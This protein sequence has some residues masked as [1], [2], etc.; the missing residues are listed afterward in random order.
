[1]HDYPASLTQAVVLAALNEPRAAEAKASR[2]IQAS[3]NSPHALLIRAR[4]R[5]FAGDLQGA[6]A[7]VSHGLEM[8]PNEP[9]LQEVKAAVLTAAGRP[10]EALKELRLISSEWV[11]HPSID[12]CR[13]EA[14][15]MLGRH[16]SA[17]TSWSLA[18]R[19][20]PQRAEA[21]LGR[22]RSRL[23]QGQWSEAVVD[24]SR[25]TSSAHGD[26]GLEGRAF[27][28]LTRCLAFEPSLARRWVSMGRRLA[29]HAWEQWRDLNSRLADTQSRTS[30]L[31]E[32]SIPKGS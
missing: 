29:V 26:L 1:M 16:P 13:A 27:L 30:G 31:D 32:E 14:Y 5:Q 8:C 2:A 17:I 19:K 12:I 25:A 18:I 9:G 4:V 28:S 21:Y 24:L 3:P 11:Q 23:A 22:A 20:D 15:T 7:D 6:M 10:A